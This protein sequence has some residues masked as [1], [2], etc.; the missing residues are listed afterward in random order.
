MTKIIEIDANSGE[1]IEREADN[2]E[3]AQLALDRA[4]Y[5]ARLAELNDKAI[6]KNA[7]LAKLGITEEEIKFLLS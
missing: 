4:R 2:T 1:V 5:E 7:I 6:A 3:Q